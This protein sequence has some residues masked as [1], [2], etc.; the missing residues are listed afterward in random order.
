[1][2]EAV[3]SSRFFRESGKFR[4]L[5]DKPKNSREGVFGLDYFLTI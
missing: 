5:V 1:M 4:C 3:V 2:E